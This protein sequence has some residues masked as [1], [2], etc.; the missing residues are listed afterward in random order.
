[1][2]PREQRATR[3]RPCPICGHSN[4]CF[5]LTGGDAVWC[6]RMPGGIPSKDGWIHRI[7]PGQ[8][9]AQASP[10]EPAPP[11]GP[12]IDFSEF[13][14]RWERVVTSG[15]ARRLAD[16]L[17]VNVTSLRRQQ[18][19]WSTAA[20]LHRAGTKCRGRGCWTFPMRNG[21]D[22]VV[23]V[24]LRTLDGFKYSVHGSDG[25]GLFIPRGIREPRDLIACEGPTSC[26]ALS[27]LG[28]ATVGRPNCRAGVENLRALCHRWGP[29]RLF[30]VGDNDKPDQNG[31]LAGQSG[32]RDVAAMLRNACPVVAWALPPPWHKDSRDWV[33][34]GAE[35]PEVIDRLADFFRQREARYAG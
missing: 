18:L 21:A 20:D 12:L 34:A 15:M 16:S 5:F 19:G 3:Q 1:M 26:A 17:Q 33:I 27:M 30:I 23:G 7:A 13:A 35:A 11:P 31:R 8:K 28:L 14:R 22:C 24:R 2:I 4:W 32:A 25:S 6:A 10:R 9:P 29:H